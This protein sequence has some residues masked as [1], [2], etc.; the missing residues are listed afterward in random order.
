MVGGSHPF[1]ITDD[2]NGGGGG[3]GTQYTTPVSAAMVM[4]TP[5]AAMPNVLY[6]QCSNHASM[7]WKINLV[8]PTSASMLTGL[9]GG[10]YTTVVTDA[11]GCMATATATVVDAPVLPTATLMKSGNLNCA[12][13]LTGVTL[14]AGTG[15]MYDFGTGFAATNTFTAMMVNTYT[16]TVKGANGCTANSSV[17]VTSNTTAPVANVMGS[18]TFCTGAST[19][20]IASPGFTTYAW[21]GGT[22]GTSAN[23]RTF[24]TA[25]M[26]SVTITGANGCTTVKNFT[27]V[28]NS[29]PTLTGASIPTVCAG[30]ALAGSVTMTSAIAATT[31]W[32]ASG[33]TATG[34]NIS[35]PSAT[36]AMGGLYVIRATNACGTTSVTA[37]ATVK[38]TMPITVAVNNASTLGGSTGSIYVTAPAGSGF[39]WM[40]STVTTGVRTNLPVGVYQV[41]VSPPTLNTTYCPVVR[42]I[43]IN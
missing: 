23:K 37:T 30:S 25:G 24:T 41:T 28:I 34:T 15:A 26:Y 4:F 39:S 10:N 12:N 11:N 2:A 17:V 42:S 22:M 35:R 5:T 7:G 36:T 14:T 33:Y 32:T 1:Y 21:S 40:G 27:T 29:K 8:T 18:F 6:Y 19:A 13:A 16:V 43:Q 9:S 20:L 38:S 31:T 3:A